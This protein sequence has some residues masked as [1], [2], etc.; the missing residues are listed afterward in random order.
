MAGVFFPSSRLT[1]K[2]KGNGEALHSAMLNFTNRS[3]I[4]LYQVTIIPSKFCAISSPKNCF[5][6]PKSLISNASWRAVFMNKMEASVIPVIKISSN[7]K[8]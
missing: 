4:Y 6:K 3:E 5:S 8:K 7:Y 2:R 1:P